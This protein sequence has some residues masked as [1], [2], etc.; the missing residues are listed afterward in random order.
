MG[1]RNAQCIVSSQRGKGQ[2]QM[3]FGRVS[4][5]HHLSVESSKDKNVKKDKRSS[6]Q[7]H[8]T[9]F[10]PFTNRSV[11]VRVLCILSMALVFALGVV[12]AV[13]THPENSTASHHSCSICST[14]HAS[15][16]TQTVVAA[17]ALTAALLAPP[18]P[19]RV[20]I[21]RATGVHVIRP[22]PAF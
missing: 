5:D 2:R 20:R 17:P 18:A 21:F 10:R 16:S 4:G 9:M 14:A 22:P 7:R 13:H 6:P 8:R 15:L 1:F 3:I 19:A 11:F 12:Q